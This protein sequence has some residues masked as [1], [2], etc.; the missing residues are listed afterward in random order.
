MR[1]VNKALLKEFS[2]PGLCEC[3]GC[4]CPDGRDPAHIFSRGAG[5]VD[6]R[7]NLVSLKREC[8][9]RSHTSGKP[10]HEMLLKIAAKR[11]GTRPSL[12]TEMVQRIRA[13]KSRKSLFVDEVPPCKSTELQAFPKTVVF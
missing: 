13:D 10:S 6:I 8:H 3:C 2:K 5:R 11:E 7:E 9:V 4:P 12:I 1:L